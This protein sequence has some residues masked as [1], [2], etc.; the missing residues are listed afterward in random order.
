MKTE[1]NL[2]VEYDTAMYWSAVDFDDRIARVVGREEDGTGLALGSATGGSARD[3]HWYFD[4]KKLAL[5]AFKRLRKSRYQR[6]RNTPIL[7][8][9]SS[10][11]L[12]AIG[13]DDEELIETWR[14]K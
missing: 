14:R 2:E 10:I 9:I 3:I 12:T 7:P 13:E 6:I 4:S 1:Y 8:A 5:N 11:D